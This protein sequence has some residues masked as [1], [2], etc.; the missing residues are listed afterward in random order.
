[1]AQWSFIYQYSTVIT[2]PLYHTVMDRA[3]SCLLHE[4]A[5]RESTKGIV[6]LCHSCQQSINDSFALLVDTR[7]FMSKATDIHALLNSN[8][9]THE[10]TRYFDCCAR[11]SSKQ[12][13]V[14][15]SMLVT[16]HPNVCMNNNSPTPR[17]C[18]FVCM[19]TSSQSATRHEFYREN[20]AFKRTSSTVLSSHLIL[21][22]ASNLGCIRRYI[23][24]YW[25]Y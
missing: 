13:P 25:I 15:I 5:S 18:D 9:I 16:V 17:E 8:Q 22:A 7:S 3:V 19:Q 20:S 1:M 11:T 23:N 4:D 12:Q 2:N 10:G 14:T 24:F 6:K 21:A